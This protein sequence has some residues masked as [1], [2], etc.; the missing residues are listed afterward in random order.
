MLI[1]TSACAEESGAK[2]AAKKQ[3]DTNAEIKPVPAKPLPVS[4][5]APEAAPQ[6]EALAEA[7][8]Q[9]D[10]IAE[11]AQ[12]LAPAA[13]TDDTISKADIQKVS[14]AFGNFIGRNLK[15]PGVSFDLD[16]IIKGMRDGYA[17]KPSPMS[18][19]EY[20]A[21]MGKIQ[22]QAFKQMTTE[23]LKAANEFLD[24]NYK[25]D[26]VVVVVP[27]KLQYVINQE[28]TGAVVEPNFAPQINYVGKFIDGTSF[29]SS[30][31]AGG[32]ITIPLDKTIPGFSKGIVGMKEGEKRT[33]YVHPD[34]G[35]GTTGHL[36]PN[37][38]LIF[39]IEVVKANAPEQVQGDDLSEELTL[40]D[41]EDDLANDDIDL[42]DEDDDGIDDV[43]GSTG[44]ADQPKP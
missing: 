24:K 35:Y 19:K 20:E 28:G 29:G 25:A 40:N 8:P 33:L 21:M 43:P 7:S 37:S 34:L 14:E 2:P 6:T 15:A 26:K 18:D 23:N 13:S 44:T 10:A 39:E 36:P 17:G 12:K 4:E 1:C 41:E 32:P 30:K 5:T 42:D 27:G 38:L 9:T 22:Q 11:A 31:D 16:S 3:A